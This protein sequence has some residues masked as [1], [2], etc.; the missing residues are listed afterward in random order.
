MA[1]VLV[2]LLAHLDVAL[3]SRCKDFKGARVTEEFRC[4]ALNALNTP[5]FGNPNTL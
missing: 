5:L 2:A 3:N 1:Q 4:E